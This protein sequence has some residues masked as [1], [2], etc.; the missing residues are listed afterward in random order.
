MKAQTPWEVL[1]EEWRWL[2]PATVIAAIAC[3]LFL[4]LWLRVGIWAGQ[5]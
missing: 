1:R 5:L 4:W 2:V 3:G